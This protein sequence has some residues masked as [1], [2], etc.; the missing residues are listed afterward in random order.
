MYDITILWLYDYECDICNLC[1]TCHTLSHH[2][3]PSKIKIGD[4][5]KL[6]KRDRKI[7][8]KIEKT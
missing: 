6:K 4:K 7:Q 3:V 1:D 8:V 2:L 5:E